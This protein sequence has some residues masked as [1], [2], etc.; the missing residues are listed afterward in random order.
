MASLRYLEDNKAMHCDVDGFLA[1]S[2]SKFVDSSNAV[3]AMLK[4]V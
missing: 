1:R 4:T 2:K 3:T